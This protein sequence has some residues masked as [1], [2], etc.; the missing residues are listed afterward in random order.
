MLH[1]DGIAPGDPCLD[2]HFPGNPIVPGA[3]LLGRAAEMLG[4][5][6]LGAGGRDIIAIQRMKFRA[7]LAPETPFDLV[8]SAREDRAKLVWRTAETVLA[9]ASVTLAPRHG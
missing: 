7:P 2:G 6:M 4:A 9:E 8:V 5:E 3:V 1:C